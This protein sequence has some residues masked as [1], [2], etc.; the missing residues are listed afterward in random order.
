M[1]NLLHRSHTTEG[2]KIANVAMV[3]FTKRLLRRSRN[4][5]ALS[6]TLNATS[7]SSA[8]VPEVVQRQLVLKFPNR[9]VLT[10]LRNTPRATESL[11]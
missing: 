4:V 1:L 5:L 2:S 11:N 8:T 9:P 10:A 7:V 3:N 6:T